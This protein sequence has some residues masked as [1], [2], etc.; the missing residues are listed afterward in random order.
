MD[1]CYRPLRT[2]LTPI[3]GARVRR[4]VARPELIGEHGIVQALSRLRRR[5]IHHLN[6]FGRT[7][8]SD[9]KKRFDVFDEFFA[10]AR[11]Q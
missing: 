10:S 6:D 9:L 5:T 3:T 8:A 4:N 7:I 11:S 1:A 2:R